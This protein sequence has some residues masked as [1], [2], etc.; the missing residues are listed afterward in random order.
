MILTDKMKTFISDV[1]ATPE[2]WRI[3]Y[4]LRSMKK[5][6]HGGVFRNTFPNLFLKNYAY[7]TSRL[8]QSGHILP[9]P[10]RE[11]AA[12]FRTM[13][14]S[15]GL[16]LEELLRFCFQPDPDDSGGGDR[17]YLASAGKIITYRGT[18]QFAHEAAVLDAADGKITYADNFDVDIDRLICAFICRLVE[19]CVCRI[20]DVDEILD[21]ER[22]KLPRDKYGL[23]DV[24]DAE[25]VRQGFILNGK[26]YLYN[27]FF[28]T[29]IGSM[30]PEAPKT[31]ELI[32][33]IKPSTR[34]LT[35]CDENLAVPETQIVSTATWDA[36]KWRGITLNFKNIAEQIK[37]GNETI[38]HFDPQTLHKILVFVKKGTDE[39]GAEFYHLN[40]EQLWNPE[41]FVRKE[42]VIITN[43]I[44]GMYYPS[45]GKFDHIDFSV[46]QYNRA[47]FEAKY[48]DAE[49]Q[50]GISIGE[51]SD[52]HYKV[53]CVKGGGL[54][55]EVWA[56]LVCATL[57]EPFRSIFL[58]TIG[59]SSTEE[60]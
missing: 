55:T 4:Y 44:H 33:R 41:M 43:Y 31:I 5:A 51:Y 42:P 22:L 56:E 11:E 45:L 35:R 18:G 25:F 48:R 23:T 9:L 28:D 30:T 58:E 1:I 17:I 27:I 54:S 47:V 20:Y 29:S 12:K 60:D 36:Q 37:R 14:E 19:S 57:D 26:Y 15:V 21:H 34:I 59:A 39:N 38:V 53:W 24:T 46:N 40:V 32:Q 49:Q 16:A 52:E 13:L 10:L 6:P 3:N 2:F 7:S 8:F 50:T